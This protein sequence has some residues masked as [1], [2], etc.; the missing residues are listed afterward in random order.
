MPRVKTSALREVRGRATPCAGDANSS[1]AVASLLGALFARLHFV[2]EMGAPLL[3]I[4]SV[5]IAGNGRHLRGGAAVRHPACAPA[6]GCCLLGCGVTALG[7]VPA[8]AYEH[9][10][11]KSMAMAALCRDSVSNGA[12][13][14]VTVARRLW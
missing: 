13:G 6:P 5:G 11:L 12:A 7:G 3:F 4:L 14:T 1:G 8:D 10:P 9:G 2:G